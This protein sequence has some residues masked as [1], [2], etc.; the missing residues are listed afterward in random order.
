MYILEIKPLLVAS[1]KTVFS[2]SVGCVFVCLFFMVSFAVQKLVGLIRSHWFICV[3]FLL[4]WET[5]LGSSLVVQQLR[6]W[7]CH[8]S[9]STCHGCRQK[10][11][12][13]NKIYIEKLKE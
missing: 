5:D 12:V 9:D 7:H 4:P 3:L 13:K 6:I 8:C 2:H 10:I 1:F 11:K